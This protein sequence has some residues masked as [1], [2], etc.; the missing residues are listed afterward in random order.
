MWHMRLHARLIPPQAMLD[1]LDDLVRSVRGA[2]S[3]LEYVPADQLHIRLATFG[4]V[5]HGDAVKLADTLTKEAA[6]WAP[7]KLRFGGGAALE[8]PGDNSVWAKL[9]GDLEHLTMIG[10]KIP[11]VVARL[12]Y[13]VDR[14]KFRSW[15][16]V[17][18]ITPSTTPEFLQALVDALE[19]YTGPS[20]TSSEM[21]LLNERWPT[22]EAEVMRLEVYKRID[23]KG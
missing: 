6:E 14:R 17:G 15:V 4:N 2:A 7:V 8:W 5:S 11:Q 9:D 21:C 10:S 13:L 22:S 3:E 20:W 19:A 18:Q 1:E 23:L 12:G 16:P